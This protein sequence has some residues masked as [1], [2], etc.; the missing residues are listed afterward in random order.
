[1]LLLAGSTKK[2]SS[3]NSAVPCQ[4]SESDEYLNNSTQTKKQRAANKQKTATAPTL[5]DNIA[6]AVAMQGT[7]S[8]VHAAKDDDNPFKVQ[9]VKLL[10]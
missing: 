1:M 5:E 3:K 9:P 10:N 6:A 2:K 7:V 8:C 4:Y